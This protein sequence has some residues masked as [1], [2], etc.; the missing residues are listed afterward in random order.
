MRRHEVTDFC[1]RHSSW[2]EEKVLRITGRNCKV[3]LS[4]FTKNDV[5]RMSKALDE[6]MDA[7]AVQ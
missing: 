1:V 2:G 7:I 6:M 5:R 4:V 3:L